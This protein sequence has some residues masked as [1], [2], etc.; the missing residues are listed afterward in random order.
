[1][2]QDSL[3][4]VLNVEALLMVDVVAGRISLADVVDAVV[5][6]DGRG[7]RSSNSQDDIRIRNLRHRHR[8]IDLYMSAVVANKP[9]HEMTSPA[10]NP[11]PRQR[12]VGLDAQTGVDRQQQGD[13]STSDKKY[14]ILA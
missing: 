2:C 10:R 3:L 4:F 11:E 8:A 7:S 13:D 6:G 14:L 5:G 12:L 9:E 1:M